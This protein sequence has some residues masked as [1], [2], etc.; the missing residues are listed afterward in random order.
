MDASPPA[1]PRFSAYSWPSLLK[2]ISKVQSAIRLPLLET[3][4]FDPATSKIDLWVNSDSRGLL[5]QMD[6]GN[7][8]KADLLAACMRTILTPAEQDLYVNEVQSLLTS[9]E[10][11][12]SRDSAAEV[13][14]QRPQGLFPA[15][16]RRPQKAASPQ[17]L[18]PSASLP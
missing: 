1:P 14:L 11:M 2:A 13:P 10:S 8:L 9:S 15:A 17:R 6:K 4:L 16:Q 12:V 18:A 5:K 7:L 3:V